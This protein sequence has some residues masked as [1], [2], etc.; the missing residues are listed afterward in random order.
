MTMFIPLR[1]ALSLAES[2][3]GDTPTHDAENPL[4]HVLAR[5]RDPS[6]SR[7]RRAVDPLLDPRSS[8]RGTVRAPLQAPAGTGRRLSSTISLLHHGLVLLHI[9]QILRQ[10]KQNVRLV[11]LREIPEDAN[12]RQQ[13]NALAR[14]MEQSQVFFTY[15][16]ALAVQRAYHET[17]HPLIFLAYDE[18][19]CLCGVG[20]LANG[21]SGASFLCATTGDYCDFLS[22]P[23]NR[24]AFVSAVLGELRKQ[25]I[26]RVTLTN[27]PADSRDIDRSAA[28][29]GNERLLSVCAPRLRMRTS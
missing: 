3:W 16:W 4:A 26:E 9:R 5:G 15:E 2:G 24:T 6:R 13:W 27:L 7:A 22:S 28:S 18:R 10:V 23:E 17:L 12:L 14:S 20:A 21:N 1:R 25:G 11:L 8:H 29:R 19:E